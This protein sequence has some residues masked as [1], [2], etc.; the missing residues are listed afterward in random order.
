MHC[1]LIGWQDKFEQAT[2]SDFV[3]FAK[4][5]R[6]DIWIGFS[7]EERAEIVVERSWCG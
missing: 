2:T 3:R 4:A 5:E 1:A 7:L 6:R